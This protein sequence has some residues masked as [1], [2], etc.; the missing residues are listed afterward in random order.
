[1]EQKAKECKIVRKVC[2]K[3]TLDT[4]NVGDELLLKFR[5]VRPN[6]VRTASKYLLPRKFIVSESGYGD[7]TYVKRIL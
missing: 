2:V 6:A 5:E 4:M 1:M 7:N 3:D